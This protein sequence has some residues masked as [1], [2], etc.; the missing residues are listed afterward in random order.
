MTPC[1][2][3]SNSIA[4]VAGSS[5]AVLSTMQEQLDWWIRITGGCL[6]LAIGIISLYRLLHHPIQIS[7]DKWP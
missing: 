5:F 3:V 2:H 4:G 1:Q 6:G 7:N